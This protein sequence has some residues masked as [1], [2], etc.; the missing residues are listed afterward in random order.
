MYVG[1]QKE[2]I[3]LHFCFSATLCL[4]ASAVCKMRERRKKEYINLTEIEKIIQVYPTLNL[5]VLKGN[6]SNL[7]FEMKRCRIYNNK[8]TTK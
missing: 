5:L 8:G 6:S 2:E 3:S 4:L 1:K 7:Y